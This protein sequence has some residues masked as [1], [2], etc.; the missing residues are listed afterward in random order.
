MIK[1]GLCSVTL[2]QFSVE[3]IIRFCR[4]LGIKAVEWGGDIHVPHGDLKTA[5]KTLVLC[6]DAGIECPS[7]GSYYRIGS[8]EGSG[9][10][11][12]DVL[13]TAVALDA[14]TVRVWGGDRDLT[15]YSETELQ[16]AVEDAR[17]I[18]DMAAES[19]LSVSLEYHENSLT[20]TPSSLEIFDRLADHPG[21]RYYWQPPHTLDDDGCLR[22]LTDLGSRLTNLHVFQ[23]RLTGLPEPE[24]RLERLPLSEGAQ[25]W[26]KFLQ[27]AGGSC[28]HYAFLEFVRDDDPS[29]LK[30]DWDAFR[31][32]LSGLD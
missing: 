4:D 8:S 28:D 29:R 13:K 1:P 7:Y 9:L 16:A 2:R 3:D 18:A 12:A 5:E 31:E 30:E 17:R 23:W 15:L 21:I 11:F 25:R 26:H 27:N 22:S 14:R 20:H 32:I 10:F 19:G 6:R 24:K